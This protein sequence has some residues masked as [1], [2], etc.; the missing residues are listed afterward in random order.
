MRV[1]GKYRE[2]GK[3]F[4][5]IARKM[6]A[7]INGKAMTLYYDHEYKED[8]ADLE[9]CFPVRKG[10]IAEGISIRELEGGRAVTLI[11]KG[12]YENIG[13]SYKRLFDYIH[14]KKYSTLLPSR[15]VYLKGPGMILRGNPRNYL[16]ELQ[17]MIEE[18][19]S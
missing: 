16:T 9:P 17:V 5:I 10:G 6:G 3:T 11:H 15:E 4:G 1:H 12:P 8:D 18:A 2:V 19:G 14:Q 7:R 13:E